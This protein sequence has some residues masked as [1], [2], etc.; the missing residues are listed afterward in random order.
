MLMQGVTTFVREE[1]GGG[2]EAA[3]DWS[4]SATVIFD[5]ESAGSPYDASGGSCSGCDLTSNGSPARATA[6]PIEGSAYLTTGATDYLE[7]DQ[8]TDAACTAIEDITS[9]FCSMAWANAT[10]DANLSMNW[11]R[12][13]SGGYRTRRGGTCDCNNFNVTGDSSVQHAGVTDSFEV[14]DGWTHIVSCFNDTSNEMD[15]YVNGVASVTAPTTMDTAMQ[16]SSGDWRIGHNSGGMV[17]DTDEVVIYEGE[18]FTAPDAC[19]ICSCGWDG[20]DCTV[21][22]S[23]WTDKG[24]N[25]SN[26]GTC[27]LCADASAANPGACS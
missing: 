1:A 16:A 11:G 8:A 18:D 10:S 22:G 2:P 21:T 19:R 17:G 26:C 6:S 25:V 24:K 7:C 13:S 3:S 5:F 14:A 9:S 20:A 23:S 15:D 27:T 4:A 12:E